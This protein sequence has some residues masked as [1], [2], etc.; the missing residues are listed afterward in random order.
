VRDITEARFMPESAMA[1]AML[2]IHD[3]NAAEF[4]KEDP[5]GA[6]SRA[7]AAMM[8]KQLE[9]GTGLSEQR[10]RY[11]DANVD[12]ILRRERELKAIWARKD[13]EASKMLE[14]LPRPGAGSISL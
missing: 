9:E 10:S 4:P 13:A 2:R 3:K 7:M 12:T 1:K 5:M 14:A 8:R 6:M 11:G